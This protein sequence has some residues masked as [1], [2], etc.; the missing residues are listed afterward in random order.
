MAVTLCLCGALRAEDTSDFEMFVD[1]PIGFWDMVSTGTLDKANTE[2]AHS[3]FTSMKFGLNAGK[4]ATIYHTWY[5]EYTTDITTWEWWVYPDGPGLENLNLQVRI[6]NQSRRPAVRLGDLVQLTPG[7]WNRIDIPISALHIT[8]GET[9]HYMYLTAPQGQNM[10]DFW[11]DD[12]KLVKRPGP[13]TNTTININ[14]SHVLHHVERRDFG[15]GIHAQDNTTEDAGTRARMREAGITFMNFPGGT[16]ADEYDWVNSV[17][18]RTGS[19]CRL[20]TDLYLELSEAIG[21]D[22]MIAVNYGSGT[23]EEAANWVNYANIQNNA[24]IKYWSIG[25]EC[26]QP[27]E[28]DT[29]TGIY[30]H[31]AETYAAFAVET[32]QRMKAIDPN[33]KVGV[34]GAYG[35]ESFPGRTTVTNPRTGVQTNGWS[36]V[37]LTRMREASVLPDYYDIHIYTVPPG[38]ESDA[39]LFQNMDRIDFWT[40]RVRQ[41]LID[42]LGDAG[43]TMPINMTESNSTWSTPGIQSVSLTNGMYLV[44]SWAQMMNRD[45]GCWVW[46]KLHN[47]T[48]TNGNDHPSIFGWREYSDFGI[49]ARGIPSDI[50]PPLNTPYPT[51]YAFKMLKYFARAGD[52]IVECVTN[53][54]HLKAFACKGANGRLRLLIINSAKDTD[55]PVKVTASG[56]GLPGAATLHRYGIQED[57]NQSDISTTFVT[58]GLPTLSGYNRTLRTTIRSYSIN[59]FEF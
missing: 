22:K 39:L 36:A 8:E 42:Y 44:Y 14:P 16:N 20:T 38:H 10:P 18:R 19:Y 5:G 54:M 50:S 13:G 30:N 9:L 23:P 55:I 47:Q 28:Y 59:V 27:G 58:F 1:Y 40:G 57:E 32:I 48:M 45:I 3:F 33:V 21:A 2:R 34:V 56:S 37:V 35:E 24:N 29:R 49:L 31:D 7:Q 17:N 43:A 11:I 46:W 15:I 52:D 26:Y 12:M 53:N 41:M 25:N 4:E 51:F 6:F